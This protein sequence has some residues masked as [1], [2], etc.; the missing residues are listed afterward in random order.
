MSKRPRKNLRTA[1]LPRLVALTRVAPTPTLLA[2][3]PALAGALGAVPGWRAQVAGNMAAALGPDGFRREDV[4]AYFRHVA[5]LFVYSAAV[6]RSGVSDTALN[7][8]WE[9]DPT[10]RQYYEEALE[11]GKGVVMVSPHLVCHEIMAGVSAG[12]GL[13]VTALVRKAPDPDYEGIKQ[14]WYAA[15]GVEV[16]YRPPKGSP[17]QG[18]GEMTAALRVLRKNRVLAI[19]PDLIQKP[20]SGIRVALFGREAELPAGAF[21]LSARTGAP[22]LPSFFHHEAGRYRLWTHPPLRVDAGSDLNAGISEGAQQWAALFEAF[23]REHPDMWQFWLDKRWTRW[24][25]NATRVES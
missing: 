1:L 17:T 10:S 7:G 18:L 19:T 6:Y 5:D 8:Q 25:R 11:L 24:L 20:G 2:L 3:R 13:P 16:V 22:I 23:V 14:R 12:T 15:L 9:Y 4:R 21:F